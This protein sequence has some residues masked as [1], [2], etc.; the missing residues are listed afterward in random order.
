MTGEGHNPAK[1]QTPLPNIP[2]AGG[3]ANTPQSEAVDVGSLKKEAVS[4]VAW[5]VAQKWAIRVTALVT[6]AILTRLL[7]PAD[8]GVVAVSLA[9]LP[10]LQLLADLGFSTFL[11]Q[12]KSLTD[13][14][15]STAFW[16]TAV[17]GILL[18]AL[19]IL[20]APWAG[21]FLGT[22]EVT[23]VLRML[24][25]AVLIITIGS[26][27]MAHLR[28]TMRF[29][30]LAIQ[31]TAAA[32]LGQV[33]AIGLAVL[34]FGVWALVGQALTVHFVSTTL[35]WVTIRWHPSFTFSWQELRAMAG[36]GLNVAASDFMM[37]AR[38][39]IENAI[40]V[41][42]LGVSGLGYLNIA[43]RLIQIT[44]DLTTSTLTP[45]SLVVFAQIRDQLAKLRSAY[46]SALTAI[47]TFITP[48]LI[49][50]AVDAHDIIP[51]AFGDQWGP[52]I[53]PARAY[54]VAAVF[55]LIALDQALYYGVGAPGTWLIYVAVIE[56]A[57][58]LV[59]LSVAHLGLTAVAF[60]FMCAAACA[61]WVRWVMI[62][63]RLQ[64]AWWRIATPWARLLL[65][66]GP[67]AG[68]S[69][70]ASMLFNGWSPLL[71]VA[72][73]GIVLLLSY[74]LALRFLLPGTWRELKRHTTALPSRLQ[75][76]HSG[77]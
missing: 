49:F 42:V 41:S 20:I 13:K 54:A 4:G 12:T 76:R 26:V 62:G 70:G 11:V 31:G 9:F 18:V 38:V 74:G 50:I 6:V 40:I 16:Y 69:T 52:S 34:G 27:P 73:T 1:D 15:Y 45:V 64:T 8:F 63:R 10:I 71:R 68:L 28:R 14:T 75:P 39:W 57:T 58:V 65:V 43:Q 36:F 66:I 53:T 48:L 22:P 25:P 72:S 59:T 55:T 7:T 60:G 30:A 47:L 35:A 46:I 51:L 2:P 29:R 17:V 21:A 19:L 77:A 56:G 44:E 24:A 5:S 23:P 67:A 3:F 37:I 61:A 32:F 33:V